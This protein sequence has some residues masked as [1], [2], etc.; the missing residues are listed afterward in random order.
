[1]TAYVENTKSWHG[2]VGNYDC[3]DNQMHPAFQ[4][5]KELRQMQ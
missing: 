4:I 2:L 1:M 3:L 5:S